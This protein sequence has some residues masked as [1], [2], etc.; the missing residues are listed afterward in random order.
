MTSRRPPLK[1]SSTSRRTTVLLASVTM[2][3]PDPLADPRFKVLSA[4]AHPGR[5]GQQVTALQSAAVPLSAAVV[6]LDAV[7]AD[8]RRWWRRWTPASRSRLIVHRAAAGGPWSWWA[9]SG[10][11]PAR[12]AVTEPTCW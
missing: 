9:A 2:L 8:G 11:S 3:L 6:P 1:T 4:P 5:L 10:W 12:A 7:G